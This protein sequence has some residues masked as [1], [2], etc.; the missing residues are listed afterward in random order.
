FVSGGTAYDNG[1]YVYNWTNS[2]DDELN[3]QTQEELINESGQSYYK[4]RL[5]NIPSGSYYLTIE[6]KN[7]E[8]ADTKFG[9]T[10]IESEYKLSEPIEAIIEVY[11]P[12]SCNSLNGFLDPSSDGAL[13]ARVEGGI[14]FS[15]GQPYNY[16]WKKLDENGQWVILE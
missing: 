16:I 12:V 14:P 15:A 6:D 7:Y 2:S 9:C 4:I 8:V 11:N 13:V 5:I 1:S 10:L 3:G